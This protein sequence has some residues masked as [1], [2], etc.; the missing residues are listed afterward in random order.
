MTDSERESRRRQR[1]KRDNTLGYEG[2]SHHRHAHQAERQKEYER[3]MN[4]GQKDDDDS[5]D[6][7]NRD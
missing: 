1:Y 3:Y 4:G 6:Y 7:Y 2:R 5:D